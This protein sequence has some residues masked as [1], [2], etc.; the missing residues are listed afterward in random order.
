M[1]QHAS[2]PVRQAFD[3]LAVTPL[4]GPDDGPRGRFSGYLAC[5]TLDS[6]GDIIER[7]AFSKTLGEMRARQQ[8]RAGTPG[9]RYL[10]P[11]FWNH[12]SDKPIGGFVDAYED[13]NGLYVTGEFD[14]DTE[15]GHTAYSATIKGYVPAM[16]IGYFPIKRDYDRN[17]YRHLKEVALFEGSVVSVPANPDAIIMEV[18]TATGKASWPLGARDTAWDNGAAHKR[19]VAWA[20]DAQGAVNT[21]KLKSVHFY[22]PTGDAASNVSAFKL[23]FCDVV[24]GEVKAM[25]RGIMAC[26]GSHGVEHTDGISAAEVDTIKNKISAYYRRMAAEFDD[27]SIVA[28]WDAKPSGSGGKGQRM[29]QGSHRRKALD[30]TTALQMVSADDSLQDE[31][32]DSFQAFVD[33]MHS[34]M[35]QG[36]YST[37]LAMPAGVE[38]EPTFDAQAAAETVLEQF[39]AHMSDLVKQ[40]LAASFVPSLDDDG[41]SFLDPDGPNASDSDGD[42]GYMS[43]DTSDAEVKSGRIMSAANH[44]AMGGM[45]ADMKKSMDALAATHKSLTAF[46]AKVDPNAKPDAATTDEGGDTTSS[47]GGDAP[48]GKSLN[49]TAGDTPATSETLTGAGAPPTG[50]S[51]TTPLTADEMGRLIRDRMT[52]ARLAQAVG[53]ATA[54]D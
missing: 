6:Q 46:H 3:L 28:P 43:A 13:S 52:A 51:V 10:F 45:L 41:D 49:T 53:R 54:Q 1:T 20:T 32:G 18:K 25:P 4:D 14:L 50:V 9:G 48:G 36:V 40:S 23:L 37:M 26:A 22:S 44:K 19:I 12:D 33:A 15:L 2:A 30:F 24:G 35:C 47:G 38:D 34:V 8:K 16:S 21:A 39:S 29:P 11:I 27:K 7:G 42:A 17:G 31:W 5:Y